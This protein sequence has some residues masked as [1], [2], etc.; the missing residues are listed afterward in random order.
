LADVSA[1]ELQ[2]EEGYAGECAHA[3]VDL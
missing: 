1:V 3:G 2:G